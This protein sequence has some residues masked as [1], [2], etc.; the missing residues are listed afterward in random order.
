M[1]SIHFARVKPG[2]L[3]TAEFLNSIVTQIERMQDEIDGLSGGTPDA[4]VITALVPAGDI[5]SPSELLILGRNFDTPANQNAVS[6]DE[7]VLTGFLPGCTDTQL[8]LTIPGGIA[9]LPRPMTLGVANQKGSAHTTI[10][11]VPGTPSVGGK[12]IV[13][14]TTVGGGVVTAG[15]L[16]TLTFELAGDNLLRPEQ[17]RVKLELLSG[18]PVGSESQWAVRLSG[19]TGTGTDDQQVTVTPGASTVVVAQLKVPANVSSVVAFLRATSVH[20]SPASDAASL[21]VTL[22]LGSS[23]PGADAGVKLDF[24]QPSN[25]IRFT[26]IDGVKG[27]QIRYGAN[28]PLRIVANYAEAGTYEYNLSVADAGTFWTPTQLSEPIQQATAGA[29]DA[30]TFMLKLEASGPVGEK[31]MATVKAIRKD[32][33]GDNRVSSITFP[34]AG[35]QP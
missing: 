3:I 9:G 18:V 13:L 8:R 17:F 20:N 21:P 28:A 29:T 32:T 24:G 4:P 1:A 34:I 19:T 23:T 33:A 35:F 26:E 25:S 27:A 11:V 31:R 30:L 22:T 14:N 12:A 6:L 7:L 2:D 5:V 15:Q 10:R 16:T